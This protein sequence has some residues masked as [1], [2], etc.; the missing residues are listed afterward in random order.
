MHR[1]RI[2][3][4]AYDKA[5]TNTNSVVGI[6]FDNADLITGEVLAQQILSMVPAERQSQ[7]GISWHSPLYHKTIGQDIITFVLPAEVPFEQLAAEVEAHLQLFPNSHVVDEIHGRTG[8]DHHISMEL[9][10]LTA[11]C[12]QRARELAR[13]V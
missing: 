3:V 9:P 4:G 13:L 12:A 1:P 10:G 7:L 2:T 8:L 5:K 6:A 11:F